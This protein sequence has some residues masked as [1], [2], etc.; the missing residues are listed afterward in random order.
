MQV[1]TVHCTV[2]SVQCYQFLLIS[3]LSTSN[4]PLKPIWFFLLFDLQTTAINILG[5]NEPWT[6]YNGLPALMGEVRLQGSSTVLPTTVEIVTELS[7]IR[8]KQHYILSFKKY[9]RFFCR[10]WTCFASSLKVSTQIFVTE[11]KWVWQFMD[12]NPNL[13]SVKCETSPPPPPSGQYM[14]CIVTVWD[15]W[16]KWFIVKS[17]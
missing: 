12:S 16:R 11:F 2:Y 5:R 9:F 6:V 17:L 14:V 3:R 4:P 7:E 8:E 1:H 13:Y 15:M 10:I